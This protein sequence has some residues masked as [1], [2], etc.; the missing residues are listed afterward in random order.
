MGYTIFYVPQITP[1]TILVN[2][3][4]WDQ[5]EILQEQP[6]PGEPVVHPETFRKILWA[7]TE[8]DPYAEDPARRAQLWLDSAG[9]ATMAQILEVFPG[10]PKGMIGY[11]KQI[12]E[13]ALAKIPKNAGVL[14]V[15]TENYD[16][17]QAVLGGKG[18]MVMRDGSTATEYMGRLGARLGMNAE[19]FAAYIVGEN[20]RVT[21]TS[22]QIEERYLA[23]CYGG[24]PEVGI[25]PIPQLPTI[26]A[27]RQAVIDFADFCG[28]SIPWGPRD[29]YAE[30]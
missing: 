13:Y 26:T 2:V 21:P 23:L 8:F 19:Q 18:E 22:V 24:H 30:D 7:A 16:A 29:A 20:R 27:M 9:T 5:P 17:A 12:R 28:E 6:N 1:R 4:D 15:Y 11:V 25:L 3:A 10:I 14:A